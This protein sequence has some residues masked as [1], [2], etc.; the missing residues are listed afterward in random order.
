MKT[1]EGYNRLDIV[2]SEYVRWRISYLAEHP[3]CV[4]CK[5][6]GKQILADELDHITPRQYGGELMSVD[7]VQG[8]CRSHHIQKTIEDRIK[9]GNKT[10]EVDEDGIPTEDHW[11]PIKREWTG[12]MKSGR[13]WSKS[14][15]HP[16][17]V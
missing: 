15:H 14:G 1:I 17:K 2:K 5:D 4:R 13:T 7:N 3:F 9:Y 10:D 12:V 8:L 11:D 16:R 6:E